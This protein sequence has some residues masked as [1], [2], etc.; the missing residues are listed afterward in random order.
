MKEK[1]TKIVLDA[2]V[3]NHFVRG[4]LLSLL[5]NILPEYEFIVLNI[6]KQELPILILSTLDKQIKE[7]KNI[8]EE[9]FGLSSGEKKEYFRLTATNGLRLG[10]GES[11][12]MVYCR[13]HKE[14]VGSSNTKDITRYCAENNITFLTTNDFLYYAIKR[15]LLSIEQVVD[16][17]DK[18]RN[19]GSFIPIVDFT[20]YT[21]DKLEI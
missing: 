18:V 6:V 9:V 2:D 14:V 3:I 8:K 20:K 13:F 5:P 7:K 4:G 12:C 15:E 1:K 21:C 17:V 16:F 11:A 10:R 19:L